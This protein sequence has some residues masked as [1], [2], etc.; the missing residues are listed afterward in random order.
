MEVRVV[1]AWD[2]ANLRVMGSGEKVRVCTW[3]LHTNKSNFFFLKIF[4]TKFFYYIIY[5]HKYVHIQGL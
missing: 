3:H 4:L 1:I 5:A 2:R